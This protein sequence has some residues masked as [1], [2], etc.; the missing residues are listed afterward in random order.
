MGPK[1]LGGT[2]PKGQGEVVL[3][4]PSWLWVYVGLE[5]A[6][7]PPVEG[8]DVKGSVGL[9]ADVSITVGVPP[10]GQASRTCLSLRM[11]W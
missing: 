8:H 6:K 2:A 5:V 11:T 9:F 4:P 7:S 10:Q 3:H 1:R